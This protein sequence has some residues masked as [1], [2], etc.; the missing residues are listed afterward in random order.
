MIGFNLLVVVCLLYVVLLFVV[1]FAAER[2]AELGMIGWLR[3]PWV[4]TLS[5]SIY[6]TAWTFYGAVGYAVNSGLEFVTIYLGPTLVLVGWW[7]VLRKLVRIG[8]SQRI[9]SV[10][11]LVSSRYGKSNLLG[12]FVTLLA[13][14]GTT[15]YIALQ[16]QSVTLSFSVFSGNGSG[17]APTFEQLD[18][19]ALAVAAGLTV[20]TILFGT[21]TLDVNERHHGVVTAIA[22]E[23]VVKLFA[24]LAVGVFVVWGVADGP[25]DIA[26]RIRTSALAEWSPAPGRWAG[27][28]FLSAAA[29]LCLPRM[30]QVM[31]VEN[32]EERHLAVASWAFPLYLF[33]M[34][35]FVIPIAVV[36]LSVLPNG[37]PDL[38]VLTVPLSQGRD[39]LA[40][41]SFLGGF[42]SATS[43]VIVAAIALSTMVSNHIV[44]PIWLSVRRDTATVSGDVRDVVITAR[45][46]SIAAVL[47]LG[48]L[49]F[50]LSGGSTALAA[51]GLISFA[52][53]AQVLPA[54]LGGLFWRGA[55]RNGAAVGLALGFTTWA[56]TLF[57]PSFGESFVMPARLLAE[58]PFGLGWLRPQALFGLGG[59]DPVVHS[60]F[61][62]MLLNTGAFVVV[63]LLSFPRPLERLQGA[64]FVN[65]YEHSSNARGWSSSSA[66]AEDLLMMSQRILGPDE[67]QALF[68]AEAARQGTGGYLPDTTPDFIETLERQLAG[69]VGAATAHAMVGQITGGIAVSVEDLMAVAD[70]TAQIMEHT[71]QL[72]AQREELSR[73]A[74]QLREANEKLTQLSI[75]KD[76]FLSQISHELR[77]PMTSIRAFSEILMSGGPMAAEEQERFATIIH[78]ETIRLTRLLD[79]LLDLSVLENGQVS[80][81]WQEAELGQ[82]IDRA[83]AATSAREGPE[84]RIRRDPTAERLEVV[85]DSDRLA[86]VFINLIANARKYC[87]ADAPDLRIR[88]SRHD[89]EVR[90]DFID[91]GSGIPK[92]SQ[93]VIF[94]KFSRLTDQGRAGGAGLGLAICREIMERLGGSVSYLPGQGGTAF[95]VTL[96]RLKARATA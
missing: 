1:A 39:G 25:A 23:A 40:M 54:M 84:L 96:P 46:I 56:Y 6:C 14:I 66:E 21:R 59:L 51:I 36:G 52:G 13:V 7:S 38:Y 94:E 72:E 27:L 69:S 22:L 15:P 48:Y 55:S 16:L 11:D 62:S 19:T 85:T 67:A 12:V 76:A 5:L 86:Q 79:D 41:L 81:N 58:G 63:S 42:S 91:N 17:D 64:Q 29:F 8:R 89:G 74:R 92:A 53:V 33:L 2:R 30:F 4:Y 78:D 28:I 57:I 95:R 82:V 26:Q 3:S 61:W 34:S 10:A 80:L 18:T 31:V 45:R 44:M 70:E 47:L 75:Q 49:Y 73:T 9:T 88:V 77:T 65:V 32:P 87:D 35:L 37:N 20:F 68:R 60:V 71:T 93:A 83:V 90:V 24:L 50:H 43:M